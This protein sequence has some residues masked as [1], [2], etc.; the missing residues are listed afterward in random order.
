MWLWKYAGVLLTLSLALPALAEV[1][2][3]NDTQGRPMRA[4]FIR[5]LN[6]DVTFLRAAS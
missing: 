4:E 6:G 1:R 5:E 2:T 3:W